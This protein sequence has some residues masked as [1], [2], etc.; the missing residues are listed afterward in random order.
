M[1]STAIALDRND[2][3]ILYLIF[4]NINGQVGTKEH[5]YSHPFYYLTKNNVR[6]ALKNITVILC[7]K[8]IN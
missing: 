6:F 5:I 8:N 3:V 1:F 7:V 4:F 2:V